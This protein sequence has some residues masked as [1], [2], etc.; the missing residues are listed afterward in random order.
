MSK[1]LLFVLACLF[2][3][4]GGAVAVHAMDDDPVY[5]S[6]VYDA[7]LQRYID[8]DMD[9]LSS[10]PEVECITSDTSMQPTTILER[11]QIGDWRIL[12][13]WPGDK[14]SCT[15]RIEHVGSASGAKWII[16]PSRPA[17]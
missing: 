7:N 4:I 8:I 3:V 10:E 6:Y 13:E 16:Q 17:K 12:A 1:L 14:N 5:G 9:D 15:I 11:L 2:L